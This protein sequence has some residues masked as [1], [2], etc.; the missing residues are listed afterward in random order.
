MHDSCSFTFEIHGVCVHMTVHNELES[1][2]QKF[3][4]LYVSR[5]SNSDQLSLCLGWCIFHIG[6]T[7]VVRDILQLT[8][9][10]LKPCRFR[11][12]VSPG[13]VLNYSWVYTTPILKWWQKRM[14]VVRYCWYVRF[15]FDSDDIANLKMALPKY[16]LSQSGF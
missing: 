6:N 10:S 7:T 16:V 3:R 2:N 11:E 1:V 9:E 14:Q 15:M 5:K 13:L 4:C 8:V 12:V